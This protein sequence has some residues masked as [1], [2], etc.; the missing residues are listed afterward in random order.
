L[1]IDIVKRRVALQWSKGKARKRLLRQIRNRKEKITDLGGISDYVAKKD[2]SGA[3]E[4]IDLSTDDDV[5]GNLFSL[6]GR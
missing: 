6:S 3:V 5:D 4:F 2:R 1:E